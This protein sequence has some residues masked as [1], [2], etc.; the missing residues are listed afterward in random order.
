MERATGGEP[1]YD[2]LAEAHR[3]GLDRVGQPCRLFRTLCR[4]HKGEAMK[5][6]LQR[7]DRFIL[8]IDV[9]KI[10]YAAVFF[11]AVALFFNLINLFHPGLC[12]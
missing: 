7:I 2:Y 1:G 9:V 10:L 6:I 11:A 5:D 12:K 8:R 3:R 4:S